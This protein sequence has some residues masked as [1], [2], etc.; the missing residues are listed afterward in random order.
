MSSTG[1]LFEKLKLGNERKKS[2]RQYKPKQNTKNLRAIRLALPAVAAYVIL[3]LRALY[4][5]RYTTPPL[6]AYNPRRNSSNKDKQSV[7][8]CRALFGEPLLL[9]S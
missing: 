1:Y 5:D 6:K 7:Q 8:A 3:I 9:K 4:L 2:K